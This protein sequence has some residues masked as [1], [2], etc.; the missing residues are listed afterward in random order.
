MRILEKQAHRER[1][2]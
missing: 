2:N 1:R